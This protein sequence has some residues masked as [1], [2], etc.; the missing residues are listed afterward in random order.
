LIN[1]EKNSSRNVLL[2]ITIQGQSWSAPMAH[3]W[4]LFKKMGYQEENYNLFHVYSNGKTFYNFLINT[5]W[6]PKLFLRF[7]LWCFNLSLKPHYVY[8]AWLHKISPTLI[9]CRIC[10]INCS[11]NVLLAITIQGQSW[12]APMAHLW[13]L[14]KKMGYQEENYNFWDF[15]TTIFDIK[16]PLWSEPLII[17]GITWNLSLLIMCILPF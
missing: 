1:S 11:R 5:A 12:S 14:F 13:L 3:L 17:T 6:P 2:A 9:V 16:C 8:T 10:S 4:L 7:F 15:S